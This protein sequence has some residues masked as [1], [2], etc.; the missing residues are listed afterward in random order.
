MRWNLLGRKC[1]TVT[2]ITLMMMVVG[3]IVTT[4]TIATR[5]LKVQRAYHGNR[6]PY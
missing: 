2:G 5:S 3:I 1:Y 4:V 6:G